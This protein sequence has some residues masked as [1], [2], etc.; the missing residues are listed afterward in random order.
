MAQSKNILIIRLSALGDVAMTIPVIYSL[1]RQYPYHNIKV[2]TQA[3]F[4]KLFID[5]PSNVSLILVD[6]KNSHRGFKGLIKLMKLLKKEKIDVVA[7]FHNVLRSW[8]ISAYFKLL[9]KKTGIVDK[10]RSARKKLTQQK[11]KCLVEQQSYI[12]RYF[13]VLSKL[14]LPV[15]PSFISLFPHKGDASALP[16]FI[17]AKGTSKWV[18]I[19][20]FARYQNKIYPVH[21]ME[22]VVAELSN[23]SCFVFMFGGGEKEKKILKE[24]EGKY[25]STF[26]LPGLLDFNQ[27]LI[28]MS[29]LDVMV[30]MDSA[31]MH[32]ASLTGTPVVSIWGST[33]PH[34]GFMGWRQSKENAI[35]ANLP[36]QPC[37]ISG[38][39]KCHYNDF[40]CMT[41]IQPAFI[42]SKIKKL[43]TSSA[44]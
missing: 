23:E 21:L 33:T 17:P 16:P 44:Q 28:L 20:P 22:Q 26:A 27:E 3:G 15:T 36:C 41:H 30:S 29:H 5:A 34:C 9:G 43:L 14:G 24:W 10:N 6:K 2:L 1:A 4:A 40:R 42:V 32:L 18:G 25:T 12:E 39:E 38:T 37:S 35:Y 8:I 31:N 7:D 13:D 19:A 11:N